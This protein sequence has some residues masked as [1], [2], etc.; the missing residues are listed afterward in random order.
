M[1]DHRWSS[2]YWVDGQDYVFLGNMKQ[3]SIR[4]IFRSQKCSTWPFVKEGADFRVWFLV[5]VGF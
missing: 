5:Y 2:I 1:M 4:H 3:C